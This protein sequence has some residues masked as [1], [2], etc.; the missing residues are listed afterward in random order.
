MPLP[1]TQDVYDYLEGYGI[2][3]NVISESWITSQRD[4]E[5]VPYVEHLLGYSIDDEASIVEYHSGNG[6]DIL[7]LDR[8]GVISVDSI[9]LVSGAD[10]LGTISLSSIELISEKGILKAKSGLPEYYAV[11]HFPKGNNNI[12]V[13]YSIGEAYKTDIMLAVKMLVCIAVLDNIADRTGGG[14]LGVQGFNRTYGNMGRY[15]VITKKLNRRAHDILSKYL[16][17]VTGS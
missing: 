1:T 13:T 15:T 9:E 11:K 14:N 3:K 4:E 7:M 8:K 16:S 10:I 5:I 2:D 6:T 17:S 12:K